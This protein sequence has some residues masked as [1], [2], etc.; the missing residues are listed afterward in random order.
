MKE[1][2][3]PTL[4]D[5]RERGDLIT[6]YEIVNHMEKIDRQ[7]LVMLKEDGGRETRGHA[8]KIR[9]RQCL[10]NIKKFSFPHRTVDV[11]NGL[12]EEIVTAENVHIFKDKLDKFRYGDRSI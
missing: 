10:R 2:R 5:R 3:L 7:D 9:K 8:R 6:M 12:S 1:M 11:W 4:K